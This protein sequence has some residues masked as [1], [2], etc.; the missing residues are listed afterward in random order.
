MK[1]MAILELTQ[2]KLRIIQTV[3]AW[4]FLASMVLTALTVAG[5]IR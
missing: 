4:V 1:T 2:K 3:S 5:I